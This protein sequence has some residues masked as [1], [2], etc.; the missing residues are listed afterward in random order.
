MKKKVRFVHLQKTWFQ[1]YQNPDL[2]WI[3]IRIRLKCWIRIRIQYNQCGYETLLLTEQL[4][5]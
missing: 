5:C 1:F 2:H 3:R 4:R